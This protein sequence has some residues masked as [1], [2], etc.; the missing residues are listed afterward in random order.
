MLVACR[1]GR[2]APGP[3]GVLEQR[4]AGGPGSPAAMR[5]GCPEQRDAAEPAALPQRAAHGACA[6]PALTAGEPGSERPPEPLCA[7]LASR[8]VTVIFGLSH[9][10]GFALFFFFCVR[11]QFVPKRFVCFQVMKFRIFWRNRQLYIRGLV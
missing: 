4:G 8:E 9:S 1:T 6:A 3:A 2:T 5:S 11:Y 7:L 10:V